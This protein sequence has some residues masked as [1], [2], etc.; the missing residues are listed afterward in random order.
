MPKTAPASLFPC[1]WAI[2]QSSRVMVTRLASARHRTTSG[3]E[4]AVRRKRK[5]RKAAAELLRIRQRLLLLA[6]SCKHLRPRA[7]EQLVGVSNAEMVAALVPVELFPGDRR[8]D[9]RPFAGAGRIGHHCRGAALVPEPVEEDSLL[10]LR[11]ADVGGEHLRLRFGNG[12]AEALGE[13]LHR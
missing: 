11:L 8:G 9:R 6:P 13:A 12:T 4:A 2:P 7:V 3:G 5:G 10:A 1:T